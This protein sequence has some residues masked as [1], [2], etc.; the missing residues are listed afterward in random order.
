MEKREETEKRRENVNGCDPT[1]DQ[2][3]AGLDD[4]KADYSQETGRGIISGDHGASGEGRRS[5]GRI[6][7]RQRSNEC[8]P[9]ELV[10]GGCVSV[11]QKENRTGKE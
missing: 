10:K 1:M 5:N 9:R 6:A 4:A 8:A 11:A 7:K 2:H 3:H